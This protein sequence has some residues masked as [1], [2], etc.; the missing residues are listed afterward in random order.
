[1]N[2]I[3]GGSLR[4]SHGLKLIDPV[5]YLRIKPSRCVIGK[6]LLRR[7][8]AVG[9]IPVPLLVIESEE[10]AAAADGGC[11]LDGCLFSAERARPDLGRAVCPRR[12]LCHDVDDAA[13]E[14]TCK[15]CGDVAAIYLNALDVAHWDR[16][17][18]NCCVAAEVRQHTVYEDA[19][20]CRR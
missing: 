3:V 6:P 19:D 4:R 16:R 2:G 15:A 18:I 11:D 13:D 20:L 8:A 10:E 1:M 9:E 7:I 12:L 17:D 14:G 5:S